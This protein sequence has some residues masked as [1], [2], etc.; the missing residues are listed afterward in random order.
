MNEPDVKQKAQSAD[1][2]FLRADSRGIQR[3]AQ[4]IKPS[5]SAAVSLSI[6][7]IIPRIMQKIL[8]SHASA[9]FIVA[10]QLPIIQSTLFPSRQTCSK[11]SNPPANLVDHP[12]HLGSILGT[13][14]SII[15]NTPIFFANCNSQLNE[16]PRRSAPP[17]LLSSPFA[18][19]SHSSSR[20]SIHRNRATP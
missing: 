13:S 17:L 14:N 15:G 6:G 3:K 18:A 20:V 11:S 8:E 2:Q 16:F 12:S 10:L 19:P 7:R 5:L 1:E 9:T 4:V